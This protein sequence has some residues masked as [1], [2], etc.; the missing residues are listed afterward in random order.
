MAYSHFGESFYHEQML[1]FV[2]YYYFFCVCWDDHVVLSSLLFM[3][4]ITLIDLC[5]LNHPCNPEMN[6]SWSRV[7]SFLY[8][9]GLSKV[10]LTFCWRFL[11]LY[12][13]KILAYNFLFLYCLCLILVSGWQWPYRMNLGVLPPLQ[14]LGIVWEG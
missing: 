1:H 10:L 6:P 8:I 9:A 5:M 7:W 14:F 3:W 12:S 13:S 11:H 2:K 4:C